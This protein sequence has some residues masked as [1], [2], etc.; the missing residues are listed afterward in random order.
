MQVDSRSEGGITTSNLLELLVREYPNGVSFDP[1][2]VRLLRRKMPIED[3]QIKNIQDKMFQLDNGLWFSSEMVSGNDSR[4]ALCEQALAWVIEYGYFAVEKLFQSFYEDFFNLATPEDFAAFL[5]HLGFSVAKGE[6]D[7]FYCFDPPP[8]LADCLTATSKEIS[9]LLEKADGTLTLDEVGGTM[10]HLT[11]EAL[12]GIRAKF[13]PEVHVAEVGGVPCWCFMEAIYLPEDFSEKLTTIVD[14]LVALNEKISSAKLEFALNLFYRTRFREEYA[15]L[16]DDTFIHICAKHYQ[17][18]SYVFINSKKFR[19]RTNDVSK[20]DRRVRSSNTRFCN[21]NIPIGSKLVFAKDNNVIC[22]V[23]NDINQVEYNGKNWAIS[24]L[25]N[26]LFG[27]SSQNGFRQFRY[28]GELLWQRRLRLEG[29]CN[30]G[31]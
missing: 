18:G 29:A 9:N 3:S 28:E 2:A 5:R 8:G 11:A 12:E 13:L 14:T 27:V 21:L 1:M 10:P 16:D 20:S 26:H 17:G 19:V 22:T 7:D 24:A 25:A 4:E 31:E 23:K 30:Q 15:L 6:K